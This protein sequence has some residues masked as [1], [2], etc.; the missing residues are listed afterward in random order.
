MEEAAEE[1]ALVVVAPPRQARARARALDH[2]RGV[3][4]LGQEAEVE[5]AAEVEVE[6]VDA[7]CKQARENRAPSSSSYISSSL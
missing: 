1:V 4:G 7:Q 5:V 2:H 6:A 3:R